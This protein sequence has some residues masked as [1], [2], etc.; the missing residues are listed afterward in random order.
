MQ[1]VKSNL[2]KRLET[3]GWEFLTNEIPEP[4]K[5]E[6]KIEADYLARGFRE[7][8][9][10]EAYNLI[11]KPIAFLVGVYIKRKQC[12]DILEP[13]ESRDRRTIQ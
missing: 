10:T 6:A 4:G 9:I 13:L 11:G 3:G 8:K 12:Y 2:Q 7:V 5:G 1:K